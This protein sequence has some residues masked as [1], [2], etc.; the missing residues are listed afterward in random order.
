VEIAP[1]RAPTKAAALAIRGRPAWQPLQG[2]KTGDLTIWF[3]SAR[4][5]TRVRRGLRIALRLF[6]KHRMHFGPAMSGS[7]SKTEIG[8]RNPDFRSSLRSGH[9]ISSSAQG[10]PAHSGTA[11]SPSDSMFQSVPPNGGLESMSMSGKCRYQ[12]RIPTRCSPTGGAMTPCGH[13]T[14]QSFINV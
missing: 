11:V 5:A 8:P 4:T 13:N 14:L 12:W 2:S 3:G 10:P 7:Q 6:R 9:S 1:D